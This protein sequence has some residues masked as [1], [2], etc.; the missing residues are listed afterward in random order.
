MR[1]IKNGRISHARA[2]S[3]TGTKAPR[4]TSLVLA[5]RLVSEVEK[6]LPM[7][8]HLRQN[9]KSVNELRQLAIHEARTNAGWQAHL[10]SQRTFRLSNPADYLKKEWTERR[11]IKHLREIKR[12]KIK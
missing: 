4:G 11:M 3:K 7:E 9:P 5:K 1:V 2:P 10:D 6:S 12:S 8:H